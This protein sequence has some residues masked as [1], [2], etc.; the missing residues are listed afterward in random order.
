MQ[1]RLQFAR[2]LDE[3]VPTSAPIDAY[4]GAVPILLIPILF[5]LAA[6]IPTGRD[7][8]APSIVPSALVSC[9]LSFWLSLGPLPRWGD[10][11]Y[12]AL[13]LYRFAYAYVPGF[14]AVRV[15][16]RFSLIFLL[17]LGVL[18]GIGVARRAPTGRF[19]RHLA[20]AVLVV[21]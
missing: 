16:S 18:A 3:S 14:D 12:P 1:A 20:L 8:K 17:G 9:V 7:L 15:P 5:A 13:G 2:Q 21:I 11:T 6:L 19:T 10:A 4:V